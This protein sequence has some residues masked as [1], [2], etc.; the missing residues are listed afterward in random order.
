MIWSSSFSTSVRA[1]CLGWDA[2][3]RLAYLGHYPTERNYQGLENPLIDASA[4]VGCVAGKIKCR[5]RLGGMLNYYYR[6]AA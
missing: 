1:A 6:E 5:E 2:G 3:V 4:R